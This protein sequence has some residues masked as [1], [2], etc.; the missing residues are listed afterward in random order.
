MVARRASGGLFPEDRRRSRP[1]PSTPRA[2]EIA[3]SE[4]RSRVLRLL[5]RS[6]FPAAVTDSKTVKTSNGYRQLVWPAGWPDITAS[7]P[8]LN[9][10]WGIETKSTSGRLR[11]SQIERH[12]ELRAAGW[13]ITVPRDVR[14][15][16]DEIKRL[17][18]LIGGRAWCDYLDRLREARR[19]AALEIESRTSC[20]PKL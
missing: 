14:E 11:D 17:V 18:G 7:V 9:I 10:P 20:G 19:E 4:L 1:A 6:N 15:V 3:E 13:L 16:N 2:E 12:A 8:V 5:L